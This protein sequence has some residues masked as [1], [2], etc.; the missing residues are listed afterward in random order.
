M[1]IKE[2]NKQINIKRLIMLNKESDLQ[3]YKWYFA[4][5]LH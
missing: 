4:F 5:R 2:P 1:I 3:S